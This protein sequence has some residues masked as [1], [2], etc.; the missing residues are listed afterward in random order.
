M[1]YIH[2][3]FFDGR[4]IMIDINISKVCKSFGFDLVLN[5]IDITVQKGE[6]V[7]LIG[8]NGSGKSTILKIIAGQESIDSGSLSIR[9][10]IS[11]GYLSQIP[12]KK[13]IIVKDYINS[14]FKE[15]IELKEKLERYED[16]LLTEDYKVIT[17]YMNLQEKFISLGGYEYETK[18]QKIL[19]VFNI[20]EEMLNR[21]FNT[22]SGGEKT[23][24]SLIRLLLQEPDVLLL[25]EPTNH[26][27]INKMIW[28]EKT[29]KNY[30][31]TIMLVSHDRYFMDNVI[32]KVY[33]LTKRGI[34]VYHGNYSY[35]IKESENRLLLELKNYKDQQKQ[36]TAMENS[37]K[38]LKEYG[39]LCGP[40]GGEIFFR[41]AASIEKRLEKLEKLDKPEEKKKL[42]ITFDMDSSSGKDVLTINN[43]NLSYGTKEIFNN[44]NL[45]IKYQD[46]LC[47]VGDNGVGK[48]TLIKEILKGNNSIKLGSNI[49]IGYIPQEIGFED[50]NLSVLEEAKK[51]YIGAEQYL[52]SALFKYLF[53][54]EN[55]HKKIKYLSGGEKVRLKIFCLI[56]DSYNFLIL[57]EPT[58]HIDIDTREMLEESLQEFTGTILF[59]SHDR[60]FINK[61]ANSIIEIK[62]KNITRYIGNYDDYREK[63]N[64]I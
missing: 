61:I 30:K 29:L 24:I 44:L 13:D 39:R 50:I 55:I 42:N 51:Y 7:G 52:R 16:K 57:D 38:R 4:N 59:V 43:L 33:L 31:G 23:I 53:A 21:N 46:R 12:E 34:E 8:T 17:K 49:K 36:I 26:L 58:N 3:T 47:L 19:P 27:D 9:N 28:L 60:Y 56:Q 6:K 14:A 54:G 11:I 20:T 35:Y 63:I 22:L 40:S 10:N 1:Q 18:I 2:I 15:I 37:I 45:S 32:N 62:N 64:K 5:N 48:S 25:D 41:R